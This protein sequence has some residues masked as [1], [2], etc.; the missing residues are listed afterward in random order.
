MWVIRI[1]DLPLYMSFENFK[2]NFT[3]EGRMRMCHRAL[4]FRAKHLMR[5]CAYTV[6]YFHMSRQTLMLCD[7]CT[8]AERAYN[9]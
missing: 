1:T 7:L 3:R 9:L 4:C 8:E 5:D 2:L 6:Q